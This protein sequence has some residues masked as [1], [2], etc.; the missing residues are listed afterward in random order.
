VLHLHTFGTLELRKSGGT[1]L[2]VLL[3]QPRSTALLIYLLLARPR[4]YVPRDLLCAL[5]WPDAD[6]AHARGAL[7]QTLTRIRRA[8]G[9]GVLQLRGRNEVRVSP[10]GARCDVVAFEEAIEAG[11]HAAVLELYRGPFLN[12]F[13]AP[14]MSGFER[15]AELERDRMRALAASAAR[16][17][18][19]EH[20]EAGRLVEAESAGAHA[21][22]LAP[23]RE[24]V[25]LELARA[26]ATAGDRLGA[27]RLLDTWSDDL[28]RDLELETSDEVRDLRRELLAGAS[29]AAPAVDAGGALPDS[30]SVTATNRSP[31]Q[32]LQTI[33]WGLLRSMGALTG[34]GIT[35]LAAAWL[36]VQLGLLGAGPP[37]TASGS[38]AGGIDPHDWLIVSDFDSPSTDPALAL[39]VQT[40]LVRDLESTGYTSVVG[41]FGAMSRRGLEDVLAR[42]RMPPDSRID[43]DLA[44]D[45]AEREGAAGVLAGRVLP[46]GGHYVV[47][48]SILEVPG[49]GELIRVSASA[50]LEQLSTA[51][52]TVSR[53]LRG[54]LGESRSS[55]RGS[56]PLPPITAA[57]IQAL[58]SVAHYVSTPALW[59][60]PRDGAAPLLEAIRIEPNLA[61][62]HFLLALHFQRLADYERAVPHVLRAHELRM[63]LPRPGRLGM[64]AI[65]QRYIESNP[66]AAITTVQ[67]LITVYPAL[68]DATM[69]FLA[70]AALWIGDWQAALDVS[71][72]YLRR[73]PAGLG[74][75]MGYSRAAAAAGALG[76]TVL[77]D[78]LYEADALARFRAGIPMARADALLRLLRRRDWEGAE[79]LCVLQPDWDRCAWVYLARGRLDA[80]AHA[81]AAVHSD[82]GSR[83]PWL[84]TAATAALAHIEVQSGRPDRAWTVLESADHTMPMG[85]RARAGTHLRRFL[86]CDAA[87]SIERSHNLA[88]CNIESENPAEWD[89]DPSFTV[90][91]RS[92]AWSR[93]L[94]AARSLERGDAARALSQVRAA[95]HSNF[96][97]PAAI[98]HLLAARAF[99]ALANVD[100]AV[101]HYIA[102]TRLERDCCFPTTAA[103]ALPLAPIY[104]RIGELAESRGDALTAQEY[105]GAFLALWAEADPELQPQV[106]QVRARLA[107]LGLH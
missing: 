58:R 35:V 106:R 43:P 69:P 60:D 39:A 56:P 16:F 93:R 40:L 74:A 19:L 95:V 85:D 102:A 10:S 28:A 73:E 72:T 79:A 97:N 94:L 26:L 14:G 13:H 59:D 55:I 46:L 44:C 29:P 54:R 27:L 22:S 66:R 5:F 18:A 103:I 20:V 88:E 37:V 67:E 86:L 63:Q 91:L 76:R 89:A 42:M 81:L 99:D 83:Q 64:E 12:G 70:D 71:L 30:T 45:L 77:A 31:T 38:A 36:L 25:A 68:A 107:Q 23:E 101:A 21:L 52:A 49:C 51:V 34:A 62:G 24:G 41:G 80:A 50:P 84:R 105:Y 47:V 48:V 6:E 32:P 104:R 87:A 75:H 33:R 15:W 53:E 82:T 98:D 2:D 1:S 61:F 11:D 9:G 90:L 100:S 57:H 65:Y 8:V 96:D 7:S 92:G 3:A 78:S 17:L 4:G